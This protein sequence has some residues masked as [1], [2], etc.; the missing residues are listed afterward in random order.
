MW[1]WLK[2]PRFSF[3]FQA[4]EIVDMPATKILEVFF[5]NDFAHHTERLLDFGHD[6]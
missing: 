4:Q 5:R 3:G 6:A 2:R 1:G